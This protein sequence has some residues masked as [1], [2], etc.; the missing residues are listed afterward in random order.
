MKPD[1]DILI[2]GKKFLPYNTGSEPLPLPE[3]GRNIQ[4]MVDHCVMIPDREER[5]ACAYSI[6]D[7]MKTLF[8]KEIAD[9]NDD[10]KFWDHLNI[11]ARFELDIDFPCLVAGPEER[12]IK[13]MK[14]PYT[15]SKMQL[16]LYGRIIEGMIATA[17]A[18][19]PS[20]ERDFL[21][22][23]IVNQMKKTLVEKN[24]ETATNFRVMQDLARL[25]KGEIRLDPDTYFIPEYKD[26]NSPQKSGKK[27]KNL[28]LKL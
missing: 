25:S 10:K 7:V 26:F 28:N 14:V 3:Y 9:K 20:E 21:I 6:I 5:T 22:D 13:P 17:C 18:M 12:N 1:S 15:A 4:Q 8:P 27:K 19:E 24:P 11:M 2:N 16:R 23:D